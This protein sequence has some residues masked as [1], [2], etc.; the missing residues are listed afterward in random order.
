MTKH[1]NILIFHDE[2]KRETNFNAKKKIIKFCLINI[3]IRVKPHRNRLQG[4]LQL[5]PNEPCVHF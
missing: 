1:P 3:I 5:L 2:Q 4:T